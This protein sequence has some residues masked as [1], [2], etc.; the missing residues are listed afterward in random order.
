M[1]DGYYEYNFN[2]PVGRVQIC[3]RAYES[4]ATLQPE[5]ADLIIERAPPAW[6][7][8]RRY[9]ARVD[10]QYVEAGGHLRRAI[11]QLESSCVAMTS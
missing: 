7:P 5:P 4:S 8:G 1:V 9:G 10:L 2:D 3:L 6:P 11:L